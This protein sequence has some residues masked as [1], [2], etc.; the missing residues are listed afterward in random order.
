M[1]NEIPFEERVKKYTRAELADILHN[2]DKDKWPDR[3]AIVQEELATRPPDKEASPAAS[4]RILTGR[5]I[6]SVTAKLVAA[7]LI[8][9]IILSIPILVAFSYRQIDNLPVVFALAGIGVVLGLLTIR[10]LRQF[11]NRLLPCEGERI[12]LHVYAF[13]IE[14]MLL[15]CLGIYFA[16]STIRNI[17]RSAIIIGHWQYK[18]SDLTLTYVDLFTGVAVFLIA[19]SLVAKPAK[20]MSA[21]R[22][23][24]R[25]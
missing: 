25:M 7:Y 1:M 13:Q 19:L 20:W 21:M 9:S 23:L 16:V 6:T 24:R 10:A 15:R 14:R 5:E 4:P 8:F 22:K 17:I 2:I 12:D 18:E 3:I 11:A